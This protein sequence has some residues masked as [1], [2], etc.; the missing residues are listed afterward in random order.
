MTNVE[1]VQHARDQLNEWY[2]GND[3]PIM[4][5]SAGEGAS[6]LRR[7]ALYWAEFADAHPQQAEEFLVVRA[8]TLELSSKID[9][10]PI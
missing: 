1:Q 5:P 8:V 7:F 10:T 2:Q 9:R 4:T 3:V 6:Q